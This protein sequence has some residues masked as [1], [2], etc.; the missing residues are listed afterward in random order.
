MINK[1]HHTIID[2]LVTFV[3]DLNTQEAFHTPFCGQSTE[4]I[5]KELR[6]AIEEER[7]LIYQKEDAVEGVLV[8]F[9][10]PQGTCD[11]LGPW[12]KEGNVE[13]AKAL[14]LDLRTRLNQPTLQF[15]FHR[16]SHYY[17]TLMEA[18][19][20]QK[21]AYEYHL[22]CDKADFNPVSSHLT[23]VR[24][25]KHDQ[26]TL[27][28]MHMSLFKDSYLSEDMMLAPNR[29]DHIMF[30]KEETNTLGFALLI[31]RGNEAYLE[32]FGIV[33]AHQHQGYGKQFLSLLLEDVF[34]RQS[35][36]AVTLIVE[37][38]NTS[39]LKLY[40]GMGFH[41]TQSL[42]SYTACEHISEGI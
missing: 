14:V 10:T 19:E 8:Y 18:I 30:L 32:V 15:F 22:R 13:I 2:S 36:K 35:L 16:H 29:F 3:S 11:M 37:V 38:E 40:L 1:P 4:A 34:H 21:E 27:I 17:L 6:S 41:V 5:E 12:V 7:I 25:T 28:D 42:V 31:P 9:M 33:K 26:Q 20:A 39:A 23:L 24:A